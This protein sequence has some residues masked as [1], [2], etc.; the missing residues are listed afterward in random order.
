MLTGSPRPRRPR[1]AAPM[2]AELGSAAADGEILTQSKVFCTCFDQIQASAPSSFHRCFLKPNWERRCKPRNAAFVHRSCLKPRR[3]P[4]STSLRKLLSHVH[5]WRGAIEYRP[6]SKFSHCGE[7]IFG[8]GVGG[9]GEE[10][11]P[12]ILLPTLLRSRSQLC[13]SAGLKDSDCRTCGG[14]RPIRTLAVA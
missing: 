2:R 11:K 7:P 13:S 4:D 8:C 10:K 6:A 14:R 12:Q 1:P 3:T 9:E 5:L